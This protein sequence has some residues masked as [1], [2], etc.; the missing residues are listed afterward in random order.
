V[1]CSWL[2]ARAVSHEHATPEQRWITQ[3]CGRIPFGK[4]LVAIANK[5]ARQMWAMLA[6]DEPY[7]PAAWLRHPMTQ[8]P[9]TKRP[10]QSAIAA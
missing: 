4:V 10:T 6:R 5:H 2:R 3:L 8:R 9:A 7:D 1:R